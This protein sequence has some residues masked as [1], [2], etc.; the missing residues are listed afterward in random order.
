MPAEGAN[1]EG[2]DGE[3]GV[4]PPGAP[5]PYLEQ[6]LDPVS[7]QSIV[8]ARPDIQISAGSDVV[9]QSYEQKVLQE[10]LFQS[11]DYVHKNGWLGNDSAVYVDGWRNDHQMRMHEPMA[12]PR[13][14]EFTHGVTPLPS[15]L[16]GQKETDYINKIISKSRKRDKMKKDWLRKHVTVQSTALPQDLNKDA[17]STTLPYRKPNQMHYR[18]NTDFNPHPVF[19]PA[20]IEME[21]MIGMKTRYNTWNQPF[22]K[23]KSKKKS[24]ITDPM[25]RMWQTHN[26]IAY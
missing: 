3:A 10:L 13:M 26:Y 17:S 22:L 16:A 23:E 18:I 24:K 2:A 8:T 5:A 14:D 21:K 25:Q 1:V 15:K 19:D 11:M 6:T 7:H 12:L 20:G 4:M 9:K